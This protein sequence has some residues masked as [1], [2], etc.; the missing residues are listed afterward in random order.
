MNEI[1]MRFK[2]IQEAEPDEIDLKSIKRIRQA[3]DISEG[4]TL[5]QMDR[6]R[7]DGEYNGKISVRVPKTLHRDLVRLAKN[8]GISLN[9]FILYKLAK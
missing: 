3:D 2:N 8:E 4:I 7:D 9:Q 5:E 6:L 1:E